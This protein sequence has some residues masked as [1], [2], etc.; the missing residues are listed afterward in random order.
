MS[1]VAT[2]H[3]SHVAID[4]ICPPPARFA[5]LLAKGKQDTNGT[6][7]GLM[8][9]R[10]YQSGSLMDEHALLV[11]LDERTRNIERQIATTSSDLRSFMDHVSEMYVTKSELA[12]VRSVVYGLVALILIAVLTAVISKAVSL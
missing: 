5:K 8:S 10:P 1:S 9:D 2:L 12:P 4:V 11:R 7:A 3:D 6:G